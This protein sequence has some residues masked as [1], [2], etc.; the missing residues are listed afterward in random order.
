MV[1]C[2]TTSPYSNTSDPSRTTLAAHTMARRVPMFPLVISTTVCSVCKAPELSL[3]DDSHGI[4]VLE[5]G[6]QVV[7]FKEKASRP[8]SRK[9][10]Q[11]DDRRVADRFD[12]G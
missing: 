9:A 11:L 6:I 7:E 12:D 3:L 2:V 5:H 4:A 10:R 8:R 1:Y